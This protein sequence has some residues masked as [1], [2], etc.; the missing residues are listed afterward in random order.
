MASRFILGTCHWRLA[1]QCDGTA[2]PNE[3]TCG[4]C[5]PVVTDE[6]MEETKEAWEGTYCST[7]GCWKAALVR[8]KLCKRC[9]NKETP[10]QAPEPQPQAQYT[11]PWAISP[12]A[13]AFLGAGVEQPQAR[14]PQAHTPQA[15]TPARTPS[16]GM[17][18]GRPPLDINNIVA[19]AT[20]PELSSHRRRKNRGA[21]GKKFRGAPG[22]R[23]IATKCAGLTSPAARQGKCQRAGTTPKRDGGRLRRRADVFASHRRPF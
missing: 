21:L 4:H 11:Q 6:Q 17:W 7:V 12:P 3:V 5:R 10:P 8:W 22:K 1:V 2:K 14:T 23:S 15:R 9:I 13:S 18:L 20:S 19:N 16:P